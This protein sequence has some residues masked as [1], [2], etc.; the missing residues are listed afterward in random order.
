MGDEVFLQHIAYVRLVI[1]NQV[2]AFG[3]PDT[4][5]LLG[6]SRAHVDKRPG[7]ANRTT[8]V[9][10]SWRSMNRC[11]DS[12]RCA[13]ANRNLRPVA[14]KNTNSLTI[15]RVLGRVKQTKQKEP[16]GE[17]PLPHPPLDFTAI[18]NPGDSSAS[19]TATP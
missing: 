4:V 2:V 7:H 11:I 18:P 15:R 12:P 8:I 13:T 3:S 16:S 14:P 10:R 1:N 6:H 5:P 17:F 9:L 19:A